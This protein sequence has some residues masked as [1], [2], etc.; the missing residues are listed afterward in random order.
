MAANSSIEWTDATWNPVL[1]CSRVSPGCK[2][3][4]AIIVARSWRARRKKMTNRLVK[5]ITLEG[6]AAIEYAEERVLSLSKYNDPTEDSRE[7]LTPDEAREVC[8]EIASHCADIADLFKPG[9]KVTVIV[10]NP[11][12]DKEPHSAAL[13]VGNDD[14]DHV[15]EALEYLRKWE[16]QKL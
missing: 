12:Q 14:F 11:S 5:G 6:F 9:A 15:A 10:R 16:E 1:G 13:T 3:C 4:Y 8:N 7:G 2:N